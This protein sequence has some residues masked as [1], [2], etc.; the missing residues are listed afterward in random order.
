MRNFSRYLVDR[1]VACKT[2]TS[3]AEDLDGRMIWEGMEI[4]FLF[5]PGHSPGSIC[6]SIHNVLFSG[7]TLLWGR[8]RPINL[9]GG[10][11]KKLQQSVNLLF[12]SFS[13]ETV[14]YPGHG[15]PFLLQQ[16]KAGWSPKLE[17]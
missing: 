15:Q 13:P 6:Y 4:R 9:P 3:C 11:K 12:H 7:D 8:K 1:D 5:T 16:A 14:V 17:R 10:D 2:A